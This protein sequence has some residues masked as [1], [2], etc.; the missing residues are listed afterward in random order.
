CPLARSY[1]ALRRCHCGSDGE[2][3]ALTRVRNSLRS[4][5]MKP[6][7]RRHVRPMLERLEGRRMLSMAAGGPSIPRAIPRTS[8]ESGT[9]SVH[10]ERSSPLIERFRFDG[11]GTIAGLGPI[12]VYGTAIV[13]EDQDQAGTVSGKLVLTLPGHGGTITASIAEEIPAH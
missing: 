2:P 9:S 1:H 3:R 4:G 6:T 5:S 13:R 10:V 12:R 7:N 8:T 11:S